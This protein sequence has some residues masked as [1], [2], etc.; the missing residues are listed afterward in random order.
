MLLLYNVFILNLNSKQL[1]QIPGEGL[2]LVDV[3]QEGKG[4]LEKL[5]IVVG[6]GGVSKMAKNWLTSIVN[7]P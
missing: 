5:T 2:L 6:R 7:D 1:P 4:K 3:N